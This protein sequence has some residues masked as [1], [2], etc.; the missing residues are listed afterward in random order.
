LSWR[1]KIKDDSVGN[2]Q[3][4]EERHRR[5][6]EIEGRKGEWYSNSSSSFY[7]QHFCLY[8]DIY[9]FYHIFVIEF[10]LVVRLF[11]TT[12][13]VVV[14]YCTTIWSFVKSH[15]SQFSEDI[16]F[17]LI[18]P[19]NDDHGGNYNKYNKEFVE[20]NHGRSKRR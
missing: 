20:D 12:E 13:Q 17:T 9:L 6:E 1:R 7:H 3:S 18:R 15:I 16:F 5:G 19:L 4:D 14:V 11:E 8:V 2:K 10:Y